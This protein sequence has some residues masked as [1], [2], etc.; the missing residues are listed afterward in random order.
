MSTML[1]KII[2]EV[3]QLPPNEQRQLQEQLHTIIPSPTEDELEDAFERELAAEG[4]I[5]LPQPLDANAEAFYAYKPITVKGKPLS[6]M[7]IEER[8]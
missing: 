8:R 7:I 6:E 4:I 2:E 1:D 5:S 3:R